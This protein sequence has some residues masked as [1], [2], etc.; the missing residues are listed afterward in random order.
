[1]LLSIRVCFMCSLIPQSGFPIASG[2]C[3]CAC[4]SQARGTLY[5]NMQQKISK[6]EH[7]AQ[8]ERLTLALESLRTLASQFFPSVRVSCL[9]EFTVSQVFLACASL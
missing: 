4:L 8:A 2:V 5:E 7:W 6:R 3:C 1:M 9:A